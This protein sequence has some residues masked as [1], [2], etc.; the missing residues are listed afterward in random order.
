ME[1]LEQFGWYCSRGHTDNVVRDLLK[2]I[3]LHWEREKNWESDLTVERDSQLCGILW[4]DYSNTWIVF[5]SVHHSLQVQKQGS[6][7]DV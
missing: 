7:R 6:S 2:Q 4:N 5:H 1:D 3:V